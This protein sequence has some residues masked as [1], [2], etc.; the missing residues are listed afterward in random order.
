MIYRIALLGVALICFATAADSQS[1]PQGRFTGSLGRL[2]WESEC[3]K[4]FFYGDHDTAFADY[5]AYVRC[6]R[7]N[8]ESD[9]RYAARAVM[10][11]ADEE[12]Q[13]VNRDGQAAGV[14]SY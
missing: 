5:Q 13:S 7:Q 3:R 12:L 11:R 6:L 1:Y 14:L 9:A 8:S 10:D 2:Q 4:P